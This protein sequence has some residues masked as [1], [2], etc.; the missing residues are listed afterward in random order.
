MRV[1][2]NNQ[3]GRREIEIMIR[4]IV[5]DDIDGGGGISQSIGQQFDINRSLGQR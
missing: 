1:Q 2:E 5:Q 3:G 4:K